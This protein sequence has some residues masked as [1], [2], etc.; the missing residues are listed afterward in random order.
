MIITSRVPINKK[1]S[2]NWW[3]NYDEMMIKMQCA[4]KTVSK[5]LAHM[6]GCWDPEFKPS[7]EEIVV[8]S[9]RCGNFLNL[10]SLVSSCS[11]EDGNSSI[12]SSTCT[13]PGRGHVQV[14]R[15]M[16]CTQILEHAQF[17]D[18]SEVN[19]GSVQQ[20]QCNTFHEGWGMYSKF[21]ITSR[22]PINKKKIRLLLWRNYDEIMMK[23]MM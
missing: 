23:P 5:C 14:N 22:V 16:P 10:L 19:N 2:A 9:L 7:V 11:G 18:V 15:L 13:W 8:L 12:Q 17:V 4:M 20:A 21:F 3:G 6:T 1:D